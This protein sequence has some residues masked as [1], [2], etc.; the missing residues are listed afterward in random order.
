MH[1]GRLLLKTATNN[2]SYLCTC[3]PPS[4]LRTAICFPSSWF[5]P[6]TYFDLED[7]AEE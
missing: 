2:S 7:E 5:W 4:P 6:V 1:Y 3:V